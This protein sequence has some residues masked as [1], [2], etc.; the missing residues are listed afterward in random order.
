MACTSFARVCHLLT[1]AQQN[2]DT[3][4]QSRL[5]SNQV[6]MFMSLTPVI[7]ILLWSC[8]MTCQGA[9]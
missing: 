5:L 3:C 2:L 1:R 8:K 9:R 4:L 7:P 6:L